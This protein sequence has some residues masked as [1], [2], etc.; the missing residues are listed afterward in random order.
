MTKGCRVRRGGG[1]RS[2]VCATSC[3]SYRRNGCGSPLPPHRNAGF[4]DSPMLDFYRQGRVS[5]I[6]P[7]RT[8][9]RHTHNV[10]L[11]TT[12]TDEGSYLILCCRGKA[13]VPIYPRLGERGGKRKL[14]S[15]GKISSDPRT[16][17]TDRIIDEDVRRIRYPWPQPL[18]AIYMALC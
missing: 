2:G 14:R 11:C 12:Q 15:R 3:C 7:P 17:R 5:L 18:A 6:P 1:S 10:A 8:S 16:Y 4:F 13:P 9:A